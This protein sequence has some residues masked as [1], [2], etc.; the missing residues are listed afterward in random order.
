MRA[1]PYAERV[2]SLYNKGQL[3]TALGAAT[4]EY[5]FYLWIMAPNCAEEIDRVELEER[6]L[7]FAG[8]LDPGKPVRTVAQS[9]TIAWPGVGVREQQ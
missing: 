9:H 8:T 7:D 3:W 6:V 2:A 5:T 4:V 1:W